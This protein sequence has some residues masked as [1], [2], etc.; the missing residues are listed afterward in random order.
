MIR[1]WSAVAAAT[2]AFAAL[3]ARVSAHTWI[4]CIDT[5]RSVVYDNAR[6]WIYGGE[7][8]NGRCKGYINNY[9]GRGDSGINDKMTHKILMDDV[10]RGAAPCPVRSG[11]GDALG[12]HH[13]KVLAGEK[14]YYGY[15]DNGH[16]SKDK[17]GRGTF[18]G[19]YWT[20]EPGT[21]LASTTDLTE[22]HLVDG[23]LHD[24]DDGNCGQTYEDG[25][26]AGSVLTGRAG[27]DYPCV[28]SLAIPAGTKPG[29]YNLIWFWRFYNEKVNAAVVTTGGHYGG[30]AYSSCFQVEVL[31]G[32]SSGEVGS[33]SKPTSTPEPVATSAPTE[34]PVPTTATPAPTSAPTSVAPTSAPTTAAPTPTPT[35]AEPAAPTSAPTS[36]PSAAPSS[37]PPTTSPQALTSVGGIATQPTPG[38]PTASAPDTQQHAHPGKKKGCHVRGREQQRRLRS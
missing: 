5:D 19:V 3:T 18:Y 27:N 4:D 37:S 13:L 10:V 22:S 8:S 31:K 24:F 25:D 2:L 30:A 21:S 1:R 16:T 20:G 7:T 6:A 11:G 34:A 26:F 28:G 23:A 33:E 29:I 38:R 14:F 36:A 15:L 35:S 17:A 32:G 12:F 9:P